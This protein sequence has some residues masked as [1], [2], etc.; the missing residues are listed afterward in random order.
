MCAVTIPD[1]DRSVLHYAENC[2]LTK[3]EK[4]SRK[5]RKLTVYPLTAIR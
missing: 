1:I 4:Q 3:G 2:S 5:K